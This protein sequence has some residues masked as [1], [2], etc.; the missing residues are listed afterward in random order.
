M[1]VNPQNR[2]KERQF[3]KNI[4]TIGNEEFEVKKAIDFM[5][6]YKRLGIFSAY[7]RPSQIKIG[8]YRYWENWANENNI[9]LFG[10]QSYNTNM[11]TLSGITYID[12]TFY[13]IYITKTRQEV[14]PIIVNQ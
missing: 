7:T 6:V 5:P 4:I 12:G 9:T 2:Q 11:F 10:I 13:D 3:M 14:R 8:I 1:A